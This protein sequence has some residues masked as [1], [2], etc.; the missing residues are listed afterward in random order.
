MGRYVKGCWHESRKN[1]FI[2]LVAGVILANLGAFLTGYTAAVV[3]PTRFASFMWVWD[4][5][6]MLISLLI[7][8]Y[9]ACEVTCNDLFQKDKV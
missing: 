7:G 1:I 9:S 3:M 8:W 6:T 4:F 5:L 2:S